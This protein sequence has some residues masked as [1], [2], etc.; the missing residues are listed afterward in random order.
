MYRALVMRYYSCLDPCSPVLS[1]CEVNY[2]G[3]DESEAS[4]WRKDFLFHCSFQ[5]MVYVL[6]REA[7]I[8]QRAKALVK[9]GRIM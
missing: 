9:E 4:F 2:E 7:M 3:M 8:V 5:S 1:P 6:G